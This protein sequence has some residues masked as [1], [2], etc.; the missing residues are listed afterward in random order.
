[1]MGLYLLI[2]ASHDI[3]FRDQ[4]NRHAYLWMSSW[5]CQA[6]GFLA[7]LSCEVS[8]IMVTFMSVERGIR[9]ALPYKV[10][11]FNT[12][13]ASISLMCIW[14]IGLLIAAIP[15]TSTDI[16]GTFYGSNGVCFPLHIHEPYL[17]GWEYSCFVFIGINFIAMIVIAVCYIIMFLSIRNSRKKSTAPINMDVSFAKRFFLIVFTDALCWIPIIAIKLLVFA[18][19]TISGGF[20]CYEAFEFF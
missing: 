12:P 15:V 16:F 20:L 17:A 1:M 11:N 4:Y 8:I 13:R 3:M 6:T 19:I 5:C 7:M 10:F 14:S 9:I 18:N 2:V